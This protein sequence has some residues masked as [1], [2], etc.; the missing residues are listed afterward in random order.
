V[1]EGFVLYYGDNLDVLKRRDRDESV[2]LVY[3]DPPSRIGNARCTLVGCRGSRP[4]HRSMTSL[5]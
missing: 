5:V 4:S 1:A 3:L 2:D